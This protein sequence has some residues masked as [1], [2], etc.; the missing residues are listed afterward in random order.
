MV[1]YYVFRLVVCASVC[2]CVQSSVTHPY[3]CFWVITLSNINGFS[4]NLVFALI[5]WDQ[6]G[7]CYIGNFL[8]I[9]DRVIYLPHDSGGI[10]SYQVFIFQLTSINIFLFFL[11]NVRCWYSLEAPQTL[12]NQNPLQSWLFH[13]WIWPHPLLRKWMSDESHKMSSLIFFKT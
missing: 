3:F 7:D 11:E 9:F 1:G 13:L 2:V 5:L 6:F 12:L 10:L 4:P 8:L